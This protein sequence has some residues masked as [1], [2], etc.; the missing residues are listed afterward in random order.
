M[1][2]TH[3]PAQDPASP[4][5]GGPRTEEGT[6]ALKEQLVQHLMAVIGAPDDPATAHAAD[7]ALT[8]LDARLRAEHARA[9]A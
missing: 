6:D 7:R 1:T 9:A 3:H 4:A 5:P 2:S 8:A